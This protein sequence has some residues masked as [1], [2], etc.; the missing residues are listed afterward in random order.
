VRVGPGI[1]LFLLIFLVLSGSKI[2]G[3]NCGGTADFT[4][5]T[6]EEMNATSRRREAGLG[7]TAAEQQPPLEI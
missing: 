2:R 1:V 6:G 7:S 4:E 5:D 3:G